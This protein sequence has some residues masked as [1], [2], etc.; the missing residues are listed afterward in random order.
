MRLVRYSRPAP[1]C[2]ARSSATRRRRRCS[3]ARLPDACL[4]E[5]QIAGI[6]APQPQQDVGAQASLP[7]PEQSNFAAA[8]PPRLAKWM[9]SEFSSIAIPSLPGSLRLPPTRL[10][11]HAEADAAPFRRSLLRC[12]SG[13]TFVRTRARYSCPRSLPVS[14]QEIHVHHRAVGEVRDS[15]SPGISGTMARPPTLMKIRSA[16][17]SCSPTRT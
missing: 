5:S 14:R 11:P 15:R 12:R 3:R 7:G 10:H 13:G 16:V 4:I 17:S 8:S 9:H 2:R 6:R 1:R